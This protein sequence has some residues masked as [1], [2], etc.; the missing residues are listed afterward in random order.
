MKLKQKNEVT[1]ENQPGREVHV[2]VFSRALLNSHGT[3]KSFAQ[4]EM[5]NGAIEWL[6]THFHG[7]FLALLLAKQ[8]MMSLVL[9]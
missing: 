5:R 8:M 1:D 3:E 2:H 4:R 9:A 6:P 7:H